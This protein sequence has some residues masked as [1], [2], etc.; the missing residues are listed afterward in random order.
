MNIIDIYGVQYEFKFYGHDRFKSLFSF[1]L[2]VLTM[3]SIVIMTLAMGQDMYLVK[4]PKIMTQFG[5]PDS[6]INRYKNEKNF[7]IGWNI[8][9]EKDIA[10]PLN[11]FLYP[12]FIYNIEGKEIKQA[13]VKCNSLKNVDPFFATVI[14]YKNE[15]LEDWYC[16]DLTS[17]QFNIINIWRRQISFSF[18]IFYCPDGDVTSPSCTPYNKLYNELVM[19]TKKLNLIVPDH[20]FDFENEIHPFSIAYTRF[21]REVDL[22]VIKKQEILFRRVNILSDY[23]W[24]NEIWTEQE[25]ITK[26]AYSNDIIKNFSKDMYLKEPILYFVQFMVDGRYDGYTMSYLKLMDVVAN[27]GGFLGIIMFFFEFF[28]SL[29]NGHYM[30]LTMYDKLF[31]FSFSSKLENDRIDKID[32]NHKNDINNKNN[33]NDINTNN[34]L[35]AIVIKEG[36][37]VIKSDLYSEYSN[38]NFLKNP[39][40]IYINVNHEANA[41]DQNFELNELNYDQKSN[42]QFDEQKSIIEP[43]PT[44]SKEEENVNENDINDKPPENITKEEIEQFLEKKKENYIILTELIKNNK[45][46]KEK[47]Q[48]L[49]KNLE[50]AGK[51][52]DK[53]TD[54]GCYANLFMEFEYIKHILLN[55]NQIKA[56]KLVKLSINNTDNVFMENFLFNPVKDTLDVQIQTEIINYFITKI[57]NC[58]LN[59]ADRLILQLIDLEYK[60][61][62]FTKI[63]NKESFKFLL[64]TPFENL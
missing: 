2:S 30:K 49:D 41:K 28:S 4:H 5:I 46:D 61:L 47:K 45:T 52:E 38:N 36:G 3:I 31:D 29:Y 8:V 6:D 1:V 16:L 39:T 22:Q 19:K 11:N 33:K 18:I 9:D 20:L 48:Q 34:K 7:T 63:A 43:I 13:P 25:Y 64:K 51:F 50:I 10:V 14:D 23:G 35:K 55:P 17:E 60:Q 56:L 62:I 40:K 53:L 32:R 24:L 37:K 15:K 44:N 57:D 26:N 12:Y 21:T 42:P 27:V 58:N 54:F 59:N